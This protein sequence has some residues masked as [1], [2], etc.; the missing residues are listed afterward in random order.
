MDNRDYDLIIVG[1]GITGAA[2]LYAVSSYTNIS[3]VLLVEKYEDI[4]TLN[5]NSRSNSQTLHFGD[6]ETN[7]TLKK[8]GEAKREAMR[9]LRYIKLL[10]RDEQEHIIKGCQKMVLGVGDEETEI[11]EKTYYSGIKRLFPGLK[12]AGLD[13]LEKIEP[14]TVKHRPKDEKVVALVSDSGYMVDFEKLARSFVSRALRNKKAGIELMFNTT[15]RSLREVRK[16]Y[17]LG[18]TMGELKTRFVVFATGSYSLLF[19]KMLDF[20]KNLSVI[21]IGGDYFI[22]KRML[23]GKVYR[24]QKGGV[25]FAAVHADPDI[26]NPGITRYGPTATIPLKLENRG[27]TFF[28]YL[29]SFNYD[30]KT[31]ETLIKVVS[32]EDIIRILETN[33][34]YGLPVIGKRWFFENEVKKIIPSIKYEQMYHE[35]GMGGIRPQIVDEN[36]RSFFVGASKLYDKNAIFNITPSPGA[37]SALESGIEDMRYIAHGLGL[38]IDHK[39]FEAEMGSDKDGEI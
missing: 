25:P 34:V 7:Y 17:V 23:N 11:L 24:V 19:A 14:N 4:A 28:D 21:S 29:R 31:L 8:A 36:T 15:V 35:P 13:E 6:V 20:D 2:V 1:G 39:R 16:G 38:R 26:R 33:F 12:K 27:S 37:S 10:G 32:N 9:V 22:S 18:T 30:I 5:S 3:R